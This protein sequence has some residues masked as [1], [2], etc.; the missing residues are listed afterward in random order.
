[1]VTT[2]I[3]AENI[4]AKN[5]IDWFVADDNEAFAQKICTLLDDKALR[6]RIGNNG[7]RFINDNFTWDVAR[8]QFE[9]LLNEIENGE[10]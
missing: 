8:N 2:R 3:G 6:N 10:E 9:S 1:M 7:S 5:E 4:D